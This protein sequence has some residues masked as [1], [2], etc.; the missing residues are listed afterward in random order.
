MSRDPA[1]L[2]LLGIAGL[3]VLGL[4]F[5]WFVRTYRSPTGPERV[6]AVL[7]G[8]LV[9]ESALYENPNNVPTGLFHPQAGPL[10]FRLF[11]LLVPLAAAAYL[12]SGSRVRRAFPAQV[13]LWCAFLLWLA[14]AAVLGIL[15]GNSTGLVAYHA[16]AVIYLGTFAL[17]ALVPPRRWL[18]SAALRRVIVGSSVVAG[19]LMLFSE[20]G[21]A[22]NLKLPLVPL[23]AFGTLGADAA[24]I[25]VVLGTGVLCVALCSEHHRMRLFALALPL[26]A[27]P[28]ASGQRAAMLGLL[29]AVVSALVL[30]PLAPRNIRLRVSEVLLV[31]MAV[32]GVVMTLVLIDAVRG[33]DARLPLASQIQESFQSRGKQLSEQDR[34]NQWRQAQSLIA[35]HPVFGWGLGKEYAFYSPG[36]YEFMRT[37]ITHNITTDLLLRTG[38]IGLLLFLA[39]VLA[40]LRDALLGWAR[41]VDARIAALALAAFCGLTGLVVKGLVESLFEKYR[42]AIVIGGLVGVSVAV[43]ASRLAPQREPEPALSPAVRGARGVLAR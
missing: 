40:S 13:T 6:V 21:I 15:E 24:T 19:V 17:V 43:A 5:L 29:V 28:L 33:G 20:A 16:K 38:V 2:L 23:V 25:F 35:E 8:L 32:L 12:A 27:A 30:I 26:L 39:A 11:D 14:V 9:A 42:L 34:V 3:L 22:I 1:T 18:E 41:E 4:A 31:G 7:L 10:S 36:F 37:D